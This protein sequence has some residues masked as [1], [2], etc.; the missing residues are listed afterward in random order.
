[1]DVSRLCIGIPKVTSFHYFSEKLAGQ[2]QSTDLGGGLAV[3]ECLYHLFDWPCVLKHV[4]SLPKPSFSLYET[5]VIEIHT[6][7]VVGIQFD[8]PIKQ[9][10]VNFPWKESDS[11]WGFVDHRSGLYISAIIVKR[12]P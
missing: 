10:T 3:F 11:V 5:R 6:L 2:M 12:Q 4:T 7:R 1:M 9:G 8:Y